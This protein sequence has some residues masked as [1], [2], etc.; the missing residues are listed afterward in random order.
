MADKQQ[1]V[2]SGQRTEMVISQSLKATIFG[3]Y[4]VVSAMQKWLRYL[5]IQAVR[6][7]FAIAPDIGV[8]YPLT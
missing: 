6:N 1:N 8:F 3:V 7:N 5:R 4:V 2:T